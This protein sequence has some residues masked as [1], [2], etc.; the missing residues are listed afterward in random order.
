[1]EAKTEKALKKVLP[2]IWLDGIETASEEELRKTISNSAIGIVATNEAEKEDPDIEELA[3]KLDGLR[4]PYRDV[5]R[6]E[7]AKIKYCR[8]LLKDRGNI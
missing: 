2:A 4:A 6:V 5:R 1:M 8:E 3:D 7:N